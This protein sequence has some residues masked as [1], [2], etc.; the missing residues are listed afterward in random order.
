MM[1]LEQQIEKAEN[2]IAEREVRRAEF[3]KIYD[4][5]KNPM[6]KVMAERE[7]E[8]IEEIQDAILIALL[9]K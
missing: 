5:T 3:A 2:R 7:T 8:A 6:Y 1:T 4:L 9:K